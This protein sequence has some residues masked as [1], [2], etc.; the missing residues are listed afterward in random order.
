MLPIFLEP[1]MDSWLITAVLIVVLLCGL[2]W[3]ITWLWG[4]FHA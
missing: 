1:V 3:L 4:H 2:A